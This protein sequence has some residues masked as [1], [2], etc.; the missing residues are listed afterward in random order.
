M[1]VTGGPMKGTAG[2]MTVAAAGRPVGMRP[3]LPQRVHRGAMA[4]TIDGGIG[5][6]GGVFRAHGAG[7]R[8]RG[9]R[10]S[11]GHGASLCT[12]VPARGTTVSQINTSKE[13]LLHV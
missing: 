12:I 3:L 4:L 6:P 1:M 11:C 13:S 9:W 8:A 7:A 10:Q 2:R 5:T